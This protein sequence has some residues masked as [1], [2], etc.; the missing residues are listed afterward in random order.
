MCNAYY[1]CYKSIIN[2]IFNVINLLNFLPIKTYKIR[3]LY[4]KVQNYN[5]NFQLFFHPTFFI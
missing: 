4:V 3:L 1:I 2:I 5:N